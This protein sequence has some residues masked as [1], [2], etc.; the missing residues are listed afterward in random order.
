MHMHSQL[1]APSP[2]GGVK[3]IELPFSPMGKLSIHLEKV[4][5][6]EQWVDDLVQHSLI[7]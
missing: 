2:L 7:P 5:R 4:G 6:V 1:R 3:V